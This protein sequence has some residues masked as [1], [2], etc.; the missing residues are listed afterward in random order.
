MI[1]ISPSTHTNHTNNENHRLNTLIFNLLPQTNSVT[2]STASRGT[3]L[4]RR[5]T[6]FGTARP[7]PVQTK[8]QRAME[9]RSYFT[10]FSHIATDFAIPSHRPPP[11]RHGPLEIPPDRT[12]NDA[13]RELDI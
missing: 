8:V 4:S 1:L 6:I 11:D 5:G 13:E 2:F 10:V 12:R 9:M 7:E 3:I